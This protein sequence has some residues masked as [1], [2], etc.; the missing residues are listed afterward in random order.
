MSL[1]ASVSVILFTAGDLAHDPV[2][3]RFVELALG[4]GLL[5]LRL[6]AV[7]IAHDLG[8]RDEVAGIDLGLVFLGAA[9]PHR[10]LHAGAAGEHVEGLLDEGRLGELAHADA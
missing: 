5:G 1:S 7:E 8:H 9:G 2:E 6:G 3:G 10:P 4:I